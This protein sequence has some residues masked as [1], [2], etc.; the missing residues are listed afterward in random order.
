MKSTNITITCPFCDKQFVASIKDFSKEPLIKD[1][2]IRKL[3]RMWAEQNNIKEVTYLITGNGLS[4]L[5]NIG[6]EIDFTC[7]VGGVHDHRHYTIA[8]LCGEEE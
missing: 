5:T 2:K 3:V 7:Q 4:V 8:E 6:V 1:E